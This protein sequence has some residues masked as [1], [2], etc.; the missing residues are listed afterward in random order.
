MSNKQVV[1]VGNVG[2]GKTTLLQALSEY[3][4]IRVLPADELFRTNPFFPLSKQDPHRWVFTNDLWFLFKRFEIIK[5]QLA[6]LNEAHLVIDSGILM[7][8][9][10]GNAHAFGERSMDAEEW[11]LFESC[12]HHLFKQLNQ[13]DLVIFLVAP[14]VT[15]RD[16]IAQRNRDYEVDTYFE[17]LNSIAAGLRTLEEKLQQLDIPTTHI[18]TDQLSPKE[19]AEEVF[20]VI[21]S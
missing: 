18:H 17:Y 2:T 9:V 19:V 13:P 14:F 6:E 16:R 21:Q 20:D 3:S 11:K 12:F 5:Q 8:Y 4:T 7:S 1:I 15:L 10:Y